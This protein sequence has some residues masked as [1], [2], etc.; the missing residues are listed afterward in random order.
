MK[1][2]FLNANYFFLFKRFQ[3][4]NLPLWVLRGIT[5]ELVANQRREFHDDADLLESVTHPQALM[6]QLLN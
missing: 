4:S 2:F 5:H 3:L 1:G 6:T